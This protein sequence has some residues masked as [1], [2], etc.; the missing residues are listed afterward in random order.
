[1]QQFA[2]FHV[3]QDSPPHGTGA[4]RNLSK[5]NFMA[6]LFALR[7]S[8]TRQRLGLR[9]EAQRHA[10]FVCNQSVL[11]KAITACKFNHSLT[12]TRIFPKTRRTFPLLLGGEGRDAGGRLTAF[13]LT[14]TFKTLPHRF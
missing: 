12:R 4:N 8:Q 9:R 7:Q 5:E 11:C 1:M 3:P 2:N 6:M 14:S 10:A 13:A